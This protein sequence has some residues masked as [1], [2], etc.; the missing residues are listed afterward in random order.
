MRKD[1]TD[2]YMSTA[3]YA[4]G[5]PMFP[6]EE[7]AV[8]FMFED[9]IQVEL[10]NKSKKIFVIPYKNMTDVKSTDGGDRVDAER[11]LLLG[12]GGLLWKKHHLYTILEYTE[13]NESRELVIDFMN[14]TKNAQPIIYEIQEG[15]TAT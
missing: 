11:F 5:D 10:F 3:K 4:G 9:R 15:V 8:V 7:N 12:I 13:E 1:K 2:Y 6:T 14:N